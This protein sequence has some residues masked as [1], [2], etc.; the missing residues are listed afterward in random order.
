MKIDIHTGLLAG[1]QICLSPNCD[2]RSPNQRI[3][4]LVIHNISLPP[5]EYEGDYVK[6]FFSNTLD[7]KKHAYFQTIANL[8]VSSHLFIRRTGEIWQFV[9]F[10]KRAWHAGESSFQGQSQCNDFSIGIELEGTDYHP[11]TSAQ[12]QQLAQVS[13]CLLE[14]YPEMGLERIVGHA[15]IAPQ[16][17]TDPGESFDWDRYKTLI[18]NLLSNN[19]DS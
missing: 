19:K 6:D 11:Y 16:R 7:I 5:G 1:A 14:H 10:Q 9:P 2:E 17:K 4:L 15:D 12:Y 3:S 18:Q 8:R 13:T